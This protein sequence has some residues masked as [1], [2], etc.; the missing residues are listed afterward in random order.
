MQGVHFNRFKPVAT[1]QDWAWDVPAGY[2]YV[3]AQRASD[4]ATRSFLVPREA[5]D[6]ATLS[7]CG[8]LVLE[9]FP[10]WEH[11]QR[12]P[13]VKPRGDLACTP[14]LPGGINT[15]TTRALRALAAATTRTAAASA[16]E[17]WANAGAGRHPLGL[18]A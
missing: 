9:H 3:Q 2:V 8:A 4:G 17:L 1:Y 16:G 12:A 14:T 10:A 5:Y 15:H 18:G 11:D 7:G 13:R 6:H